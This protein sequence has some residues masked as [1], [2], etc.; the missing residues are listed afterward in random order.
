MRAQFESDEQA[1][2]SQGESDSLRVM[3]TDVRD[4][5]R[6]LRRIEYPFLKPEFQNT[7]SAH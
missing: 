6:S 5:I 1:L 2:R 4:M 7:D 3:R